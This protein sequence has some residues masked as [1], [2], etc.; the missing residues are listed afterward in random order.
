[1]P[2]GEKLEN[3]NKNLTPSSEV[4]FLPKIYLIRKPCFATESYLDIITSWHKNWTYLN[5]TTMIYDKTHKLNY[6]H[7]LNI[8]QKLNSLASEQIWLLS[9]LADTFTTQHKNMTYLILILYYL[10][11]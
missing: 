8:K 1:M 2:G 3:T 6:F 9:H 11:Y 4:K 10:L 7:F 5:Q